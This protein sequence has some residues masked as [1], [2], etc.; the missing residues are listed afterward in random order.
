MIINSRDLDEIRS[1]ALEGGLKT[2]ADDSFEKVRAGLTTV[3]EVRRV[4][5]V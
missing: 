1:L 5:D 3:D 2:L 4:I